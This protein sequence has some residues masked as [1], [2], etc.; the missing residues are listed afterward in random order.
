M[1][2]N[3]P[4]YTR[5]ILFGGCPVSVAFNRCVLPAFPIILAYPFLDD[6]P[7]H[8]FRSSV[9]EANGQ[10]PQ[11]RAVF[12]CQFL[13]SD[14]TAEGTSF[15]LVIGFGGLITAVDVVVLSVFHGIVVLLSQPIT[16]LP[17]YFLRAEAK[18]S[19]KAPGLGG[20]ECIGHLCCKV[21]ASLQQI[22]THLFENT[23]LAG[24]NIAA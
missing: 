1:S 9:F 6:P 24:V 22:G 11:L 18:K 13:F 3:F 17:R 7:N 19:A 8:S 14:G 2:E 10:R 5:N 12:E 21:V 20:P 4:R 23:A 15:L 16:V